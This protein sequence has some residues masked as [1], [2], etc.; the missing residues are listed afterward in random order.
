MTA[1]AVAIEEKEVALRRKILIW[2]TIQNIYMPC[3]NT[4]RPAT[5]PAESGDSDE[6]EATSAVDMDL[7]LPEVLPSQQLS[8]LNTKLLGKYR[9]L[10]LAQ[11]EDAM[12]SMKRRL[13]KGATLWKHK[14]DHIAGTG[15]AA[16][17]RMQTAISKQ[18]SKTR[19][20][21]ERYRT[22][23]LA[24]LKLCPTG[25]WRKRLLDLANTDM[26]PP[27]KDGTAS[28]G[29]VKL[30][31]IWKIKPASDDELEPGDNNDNNDEE[32]E[33]EIG[34]RESAAEAAAADEGELRIVGSFYLIFFKPDL[35]VEW[36]KSRARAERWEEEVQLI[37]VEMSRTLRF[38]EHRTQRWLERARQRSDLPP[39]IQSGV[40]AYAC[41]Q[42][43]MCKQ[44]ASKFSSHWLDLLNINKLKLPSKWPTAYRVI[45]HV[46]TQILRRR[47]RQQ[48]HLRL[49]E[50]ETEETAMD[51][52]VI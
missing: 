10:R 18:E 21:A 52:D 3:V 44:L 39:D 13:R 46:S 33:G 45:R 2:F 29:R 47:H 25:K 50:V 49:Q 5:R 16:N 43:H 30:T 8:Q 7:Y 4:L 40:F 6:L 20:D 17:T 48:A 26:R 42:S 34:A 31:W 27:A 28:E 38:F 23:R 41:K 32:E 9:R 51:V 22:A 1:R 19:L 24:L 14:K 11:A 35:R 12:V 15:V 37:K 36:A